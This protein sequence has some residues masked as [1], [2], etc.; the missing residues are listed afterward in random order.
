MRVARVGNAESARERG[1]PVV[2]RQ[3]MGTRGHQGRGQQRQVDAAASL[4]IQPLGFDEPH[5]LAPCRLLYVTQ[6]P[7]VVEGPC[8]WCGWGSAGEFKEHERM[9]K[10]LIG[11]D[12]MNERFV[13]SA[14]MVNP[15]RG[16]DQDVHYASVSG[17]QIGRAHV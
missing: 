9:G 17:R 13:A 7:D 3:D 6:Q 14:E 2:Q 8:P 10:R 11:A 12:Q 5:D 15:H 16:I 4:A 1:E